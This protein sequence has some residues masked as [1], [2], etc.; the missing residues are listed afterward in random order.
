MRDSAAAAYSAAC[1][2]GEVD[3]E[4]GLQEA[5]RYLAHYYLNKEHLDHAAQ[6]AYKCLDHEEV[7]AYLQFII[8]IAKSC[9]TNLFLYICLNTSIARLQAK[10]G[11][12]TYVSCY[13]QKV[14]DLLVVC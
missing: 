3:T 10:E 11:A 6:Y 1:L 2:D 4:R 9:Q 12:Q 8:H 13:A 5:Y 14:R 7:C